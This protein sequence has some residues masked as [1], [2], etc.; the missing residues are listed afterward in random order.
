MSKNIYTVGDED[1]QLILKSKAKKGGRATKERSHRFPVHVVYG[2]AD[3]FTA[4]TPRKLGD[5]ALKTLATYAPNFVEFAAAMRIP[6]TESLPTFPEAA[7]KLAKQVAAKP[8]K[9]AAENFPAWL[10]WTVHQKTIAKLKSEPVED[11]RIDFE[12]GYGFRPDEEEDRDAGRAAV[13]LARSIANGM[14]SPFCGFRPKSFAPETYSRAIRTLELF[15]DRFIS[16]IGDAIPADFAVTLPKITDRKQVKDLCDRLSKIEKKAGLAKGFFGVEIM[17]ETPEA[18][19][20]KKGNFAPRDIA[21]AGKGRVISAHF[22]AYDYTSALGISA[23]HQLL[24]HESC[25]FA[26]Q[27]MLTTLA[28]LGIR[29]SDSVTTNLPVPVHRGK[30]STAHENENRRSVHAGWAEHFSNVT[31]SMANGFY[32]SW[33]LHPN[34]LVARYAAVYAFFI[35]S[36][37][38]NE[39]RLKGF[40]DKATKANLIGSTFDDA[41]SAQGILNFFRRGI[42]CGAFDAEEVAGSV[43]LSVHEIR[44]SGFQQIIAKRD[45]V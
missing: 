26:R 40:I 7:A 4:E 12:D 43:G 11:F 3:R 14:A 2:G 18:I 6:G 31:N 42:D 33:D 30:T 36:R 15:L 32:Q 41:A 44:K 27:I 45:A 5:I 22:G 39:A 24:R 16:D 34:Q 23:E 10:A 13:E 25:N 38:Q 1:V 19:I 9:A 29:L 21:E 17:I 35:G 28:P 8:H 37:P 20:D